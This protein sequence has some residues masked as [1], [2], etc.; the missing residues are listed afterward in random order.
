MLPHAS[1]QSSRLEHVFDTGLA[2]V[3]RPRVIR[4]PVLDYIEL[5]AE[6]S[7]VVDQPLSEG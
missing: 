1:R 6:L 5:P 2:E 4:D 7:S 3:T